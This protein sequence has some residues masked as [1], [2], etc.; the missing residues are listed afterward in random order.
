MKP[1]MMPGQKPYTRAELVKL[2][3]L[4]RQAANEDRGE[5]ADKVSMVKVT[6]EDGNSLVTRI[7]ATLEEARTYYLGKF[8]RIE[9]D[10]TKPMV[11]AISVEEV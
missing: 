11:M 2:S 1:R 7:N 10:E 4:I 3:R 9:M 5:S 8:W 6:F